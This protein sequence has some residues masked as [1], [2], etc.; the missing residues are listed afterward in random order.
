MKKYILPTIVTLMVL[1]SANV[2]AQ[3][4]VQNG[5]AEYIDTTTN[6][7]AS[8]TAITGNW[9]SEPAAGHVAAAHDSTHIFYEGSDEEG[10]LQQDVNVSGYAPQIDNDSLQFEFLGW[11]QSLNE[12]NPSDQAT[13]M[14]QC[15]DNSKSSVLQEWH[16]DTLYSLNQWQAILGYIH[17]APGT[18]WVRVQLIAIRNQD[19]SNDAYFD[20]IHLIPMA[21]TGINNL[22]NNN[23]FAVYPNPTTDELKVVTVPYGLQYYHFF[24]ISANGV[25]LKQGL[26]FG[27]GIINVSDL[28]MGMY[29]IHVYSDDHRYLQSVKFIKE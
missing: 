24:I 22:V 12:G 2:R 3:N 25:V 6:W 4:L 20:D 29:A 13:V 11:T 26:I 23:F 15:L 10:I 5:S 17:A 19:T 8:W 28:P 7:P 16:S 14:V 9:R 18:R 27:S 21:A 1:L